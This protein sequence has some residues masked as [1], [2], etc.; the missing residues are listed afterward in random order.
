MNKSAVLWGIDCEQSLLFFFAKLL[1]QKTQAAIN[2][3]VSPRRK[4]KRLL[5]NPSL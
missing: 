4:N 3:G 5:T 1:H 2:E